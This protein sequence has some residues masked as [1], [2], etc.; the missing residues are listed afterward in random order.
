MELPYTI[1]APYL[2][3]L[4]EDQ[5]FRIFLDLTARCVDFLRTNTAFSKATAYPI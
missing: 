5:F 1:V 4:L 3:A 2:V